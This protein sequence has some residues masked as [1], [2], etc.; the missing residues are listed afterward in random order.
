MDRAARKSQGI[1]Q[2][3]EDSPSLFC[4]SVYFFL[5][6]SSSVYDLGI[7]F[8]SFHACDWFDY[9]FCSR[10]GGVKDYISV[11]VS[12]D[13]YRFHEVLISVAVEWNNQIVT[14]R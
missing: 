3:G 11:Y 8:S 5:C 9:G 2:A 4:N 13:R 6:L 1:Q 14:E 10:R 12:L 7:R